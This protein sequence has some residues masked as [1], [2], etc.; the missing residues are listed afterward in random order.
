V[1]R[2][3]CVLT[4]VV[5]C[6]GGGKRNTYSDL[7]TA[8]TTPH[9]QSESGDSLLMRDVQTLRA[10]QVQGSVRTDDPLFPAPVRF[11]RVE[12][13]RPDG[14]TRETNTDHD[15]NFAFVAELPNGRYEVRVDGDYV[16]AT[17]FDLDGHR[18]DG[19]IVTARRR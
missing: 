9:T 4:V 13:V 2:Q 8:Q 19:I 11:V 1:W 18:H 17:S 3:A 10:T 7:L 15:G 6:S 16:G 5:A 14:G 12:L